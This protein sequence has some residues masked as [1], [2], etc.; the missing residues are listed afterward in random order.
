MTTEIETKEPGW[1]P[2]ISYALYDV[3]NSSMGAIHAT[4][5]FAVYFTTSIAPE[6]GTTYWGYMSGGAAFIVAVLG[7]FRGAADAHAR[8]KFFLV[9]TLMSVVST[10][11]MVC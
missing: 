7:P 11:F 9:F 6:N 2:K 3:G 5:I 8:R 4:F 10:L 1:L